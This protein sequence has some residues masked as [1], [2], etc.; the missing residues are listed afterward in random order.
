M[1]MGIV[2]WVTGFS[3]AGKTTIGK[4]F[5]KKLKAQKANV[6]F[7]DGDTL[8][9]VFGNDLGYSR[10]DRFRCAMR[11]SRLC[12]FLSE[13]GQDIVICTISMF[14]DVREWNRKNI[15]RYKE[16]YIEVPMEVLECRNQKGLYQSGSNVVGVDLKTELPK[17]PDLV[18]KND[19]KLSPK[20]LAE[21]IW[22]A[23]CA[24]KDGSDG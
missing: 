2:Y 20:V 5:Y 8:R 22:N 7:L 18:L 23:L 19:G 13:Q 15:G 1:E 14:D 12:R 3:G 17:N 9:E 6:L 21:D 10:E 11:Y 16:I 4:L 24:D